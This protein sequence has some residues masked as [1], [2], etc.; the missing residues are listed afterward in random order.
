MWINARPAAKPHNYDN[1]CMLPP[2]SQNK[3]IK[4]INAICYYLTE[5]DKSVD[6][7]QWITATD[8]SE[9]SLCTSSE[10][11]LTQPMWGKGAQS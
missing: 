3:L 6:L 5:R 8:Q 1:K 11:L 2:S 10:E 9:L 7:G 4:E